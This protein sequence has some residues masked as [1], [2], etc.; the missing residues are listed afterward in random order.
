MEVK[1][2]RTKI[3]KKMLNVTIDNQLYS[4]LKRNRVK[5][6]TLIN[7]L[8]WQYLANKQQSYWGESNSRPLA[9]Q[10]SVPPLN[11]NSDNNKTHYQG[12]AL[13]LS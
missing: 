11:Y 7:H 9:Y 3:T 1:M 2:P 13:P 6:S 12:S 10:A 5:V 8:L 4:R